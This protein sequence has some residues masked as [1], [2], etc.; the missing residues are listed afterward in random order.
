[1]VIKVNRSRPLHFNDELRAFLSVSYRPKPNWP[2]EFNAF[3]VAMEEAR[4][5]ALLNLQEV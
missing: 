3:R 1:M 4:R 5:K 2:R